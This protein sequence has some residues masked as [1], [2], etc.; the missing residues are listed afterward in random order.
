LSLSSLGGKTVSEYLNCP[1]MLYCPLFD[2]TALLTTPNSEPRLSSILGISRC[3]LP[4]TL[5]SSI[6]RT[7]IYLWGVG[8]LSEEPRAMRIRTSAAERAGR[9]K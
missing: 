2:W 6:A 3:F 7:L 9:A 1:L 4:F 5:V 8:K